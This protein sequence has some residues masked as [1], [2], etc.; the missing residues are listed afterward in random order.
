[1]RWVGDDELIM[2]STTMRTKM[3][4]ASLGS[5]AY[6]HIMIYFVKPM[7]GDGADAEKAFLNVVYLKKFSGTQE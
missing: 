7:V 2:T 4:K 3:D 5:Y 6:S 1:M